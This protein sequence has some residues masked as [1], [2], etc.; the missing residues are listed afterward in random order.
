[1]S[2][3][4]VEDARPWFRQAASD[5]RTAA[6]ILTAP[7]PMDPDDVGCHVAAMCAQVIE[8][9]LKAYLFLNAATPALDHRPDGYLV[10][11]LRG[12]MLLRYKDH[13]AALS[14][15]FDPATKSTVAKLLD[16]TP[17]GLGNR[18]DVPNTEYPWIDAIRGRLPPHGAAEFSNAAEI[19]AWLAT[20]KRVSDGLRKLWI[21]VDRATAL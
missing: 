18:V 4:S 6:A 13:R 17:G 1:M 19:A 12:E 14:K 7:S 20:A 15:L 9:S 21:A 2:R 11:L 5:V 3:R 10:A 16:L 8:K